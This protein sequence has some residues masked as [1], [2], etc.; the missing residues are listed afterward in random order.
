MARRRT[1]L[2]RSYEFADSLERFLNDLGRAG[3]KKRYQP[4][5]KANWQPIVT[6]PFDCDVRLAVID[7]QGVAHALV[8]PCRRVFGG[9]IKSKTK[10]RLDIDPTHWQECVDD[11]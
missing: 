5:H 1:P 8:F 9:W 10:A 7:P 2:A 11:D 4:G 3:V 6:A